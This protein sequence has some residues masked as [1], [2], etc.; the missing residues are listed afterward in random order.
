[1]HKITPYL[2]FD[3][4][5]EEAVHYYLSIFKN[6]KIGNVLHEGGAEPGSKGRV[7]HIMF[8]LDG[9]P[10]MALNGGPQYTF[11]EAISLFVTCETQAEVDAFWEKLSEGG[12]KGPC[13][14]LK[15]K[16][17]V[18]WQV[19][20]KQLLEMLGD[21]DAAKSQRVME[22]ML[23]MGKIDIATLERAYDQRESADA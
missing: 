3:N 14:W 2:W 7:M 15:D 12:E 22:A 21:Q 10:F 13:G 18:S 20:P 1:M 8:E 23:K 19:A 16:F 17:G 6:T 5:A 9:Q 4:N 11:T